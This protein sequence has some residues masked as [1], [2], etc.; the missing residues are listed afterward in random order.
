MKTN[1]I[2]LSGLMILGMIFFSTQNSIAQI[3]VHVGPALLNWTINPEQ[4]D[5]ESE[6]MIGG[7][8]G[9]SYGVSDNVSAGLNIGYHSASDAFGFDGFD[10]SVITV[11]PNARYWFN[12]AFN[13]FSAGIDVNIHLT[14]AEGGGSSE[15]ETDVGAAAM[16]G[17]DYPINDNVS[18]GATAGYGMVFDA[19]DGANDNSTVIPAAIRATFRF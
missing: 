14:S 18:V 16:I 3:G 1:K 2:I 4:G 13:G 8:V 7:T 9:A 6:A 10:F 5:S 17:Y 19:E 12:E 11:S 15:D